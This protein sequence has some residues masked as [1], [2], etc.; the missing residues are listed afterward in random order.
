MVSEAAG[1]NSLFA[2]P[3]VAEYGVR[4]RVAVELRLALASAE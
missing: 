2:W 4:L 1:Q 3:N